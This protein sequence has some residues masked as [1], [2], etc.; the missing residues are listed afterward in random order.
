ML[1]YFLRP[2]R[3]LPVRKILLVESGSRLLLEKLVPSLRV[4]YP[5][6][7]FDLCTCFPGAPACLDQESKIYRTAEFPNA[8]AR[9]KL[10]EELRAN[11]YDTIGIICSAEPIMT[12]WKWM[13]LYQVGA[14][15]CLINENADYVWFDSHHWKILAAYART[16]MGFENTG[17]VRTLARLVLLPFNLIYLSIYALKV[18]M[19]RALRLRA[20]RAGDR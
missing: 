4:F 20:L 7:R 9:K 8:E 17:A 14:H 15:A 18:H 3:A 1:R 12:R 5:G 11:R 6:V 13:L 2:H 19:L 16:R 10:F